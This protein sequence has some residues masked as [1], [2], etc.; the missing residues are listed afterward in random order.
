M[1]GAGATDD[2]ATVTTVV[3]ANK[4]CELNWT[5]HALFSNCIRHPHWPGHH[6]V[7]S[8]HCRGHRTYPHTIK[9]TLV[10]IFIVVPIS[11]PTLA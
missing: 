6:L 2:P 8:R 3:L 9:K 11:L 10:N 5:Y 7:L 4:C 1:G